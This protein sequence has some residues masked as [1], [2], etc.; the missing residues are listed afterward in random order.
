M[1]VS[2]VTITALNWNRRPASGFVSIDTTGAHPF[3]F[4]APGTTES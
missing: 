4:P 2:P 3:P 1:M